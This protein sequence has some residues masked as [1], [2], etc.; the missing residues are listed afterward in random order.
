MRYFEL[1][2]VAVI[3]AIQLKVKVNHRDTL[4]K[5]TIITNLYTV[6]STLCIKHFTDARLRRAGTSFQIEIFY[7]KSMVVLKLLPV[8]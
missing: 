7:E 2:L 3:F 8:E 6:Y 1:M 4:V 5:F